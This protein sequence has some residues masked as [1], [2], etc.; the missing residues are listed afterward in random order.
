MYC[1]SDRQPN[2]YGRS[3]EFKTGDNH[4]LVEETD[5]HGTSL[6]T[7]QYTVAQDDDIVDNRT[8]SKNGDVGKHD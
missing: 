4:K 3:S 6:D 7:T 2:V 8:G 1:V 5:T